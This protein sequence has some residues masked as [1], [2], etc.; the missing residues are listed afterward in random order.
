MKFYS[1]S[2]LLAIILLCPRGQCQ[3]SKPSPSD[4][5][6]KLVMTQ[7]DRALAE[8]AATVERERKLYGDRADVK[9]DQDVI[10]GLTTFSKGMSA[11]PQRFNSPFGF[12][13]V[14]LLDD[15]SRNAALC[16][17]GAISEGVKATIAK[18]TEAAEDYLRLA[19]ECT[20][21]SSLL[22]T[23]SEN[24]AA[25]YRR[26]VNSEQEV[27]QKAF[28]EMNKCIGILKQQKKP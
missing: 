4:D 26:Y 24:A 22:Y 16:N 25:L 13:V 7:T 21:V 5:E 19:Q 1:L 12:E 18:Q 17:A 14:L 11:Q 15:A 8:Y 3:E 9:N 27:A 20:S 23:V 6:I 28:D 2:V 10:D